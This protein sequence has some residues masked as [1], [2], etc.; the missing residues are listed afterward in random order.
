[1]PDEFWSFD[2]LHHEIYIKIYMCQKSITKK[3]KQK[4]YHLNTFSLKVVMGFLHFF[5]ICWH[6]RNLDVHDDLV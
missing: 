3:Q 1:M 4:I 2:E 5:L 6:S